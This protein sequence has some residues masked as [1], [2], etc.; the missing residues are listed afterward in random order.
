MRTF[1]VLVEEEVQGWVT[2]E[3]EDR[4]EVNRLILAADLGVPRQRVRRWAPHIMPREP[5]TKHGRVLVVDAIRQCGPDAGRKLLLKLD[6]GHS[7]YIDADLWFPD[8]PY[9][10]CAACAVSEGK[11]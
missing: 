10:E 8:N 2:I 7:A 1:N 3:A 4:A 5:V 6:C 9:L 11:S